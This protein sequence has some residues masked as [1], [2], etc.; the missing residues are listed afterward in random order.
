MDSN[1]LPVV[2]DLAVF[3]RLVRLAIL[4]VIVAAVGFLALAVVAGVLSL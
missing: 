1:S 4:T 3:P 2:P